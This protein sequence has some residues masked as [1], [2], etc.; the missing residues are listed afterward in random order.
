MGATIQDIENKDTAILMET[1]P[2]V[3]KVTKKE[4]KKVK[5]EVSLKLKR[6]SCYFVVKYCSQRKDARQGK[7]KRK[8]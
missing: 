3:E 8:E 5:K 6:E 2:V 7:R 4:K 1:P